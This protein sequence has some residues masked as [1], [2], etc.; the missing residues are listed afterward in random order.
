M[1]R[2]TWRKLQ[3]AKTGDVKHCW[4][5]SKFLSHVKSKQQSLFMEAS[6]IFWLIFFTPRLKLEAYPLNLYKCECVP[7]KYFPII[8][9]LV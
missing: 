8:P 1:R 3:T 4:I 5:N 7:Y 2:Q 6:H 9:V